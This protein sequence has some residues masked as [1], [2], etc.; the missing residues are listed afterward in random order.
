MSRPSRCWAVFVCL[1]AASAPAAAQNLQ[2]YAD[3]HTHPMSYLGFGEKAVHGA[4][5][6]GGLLPAGTRACNAT[7]LRATSIEQALGDCNS[8]HGGWG[9]D[10]TCGDYLRAL[11]INVAIDS[12][13]TYKL[14]PERNIHGDHEHAGAPAFPYWPHQTSI[15]HQQMWWQ[16]LKRAYDGGLRV[17]VALT[18][19][20]ELLAE[21]LNG[22]APYDDK[23]VADRQIDE[24]IRFINNPLNGGFMEIAYSS[25]DVRR[26]VGHDKLAIVLGMEVDQIGN[27][28]KPGVAINEQAVR[29]EIQRLYG[30]GIRYI[31][32]I[33][34]IDNSF[35]G[36]A[37]YSVLFNVANR[38]ANGYLYHIMTSPDPNVAYDA[39][40]L[41]ETGVENFA[42]VN[43]RPALQA[44][45]ETPAP[46]FNDISCFP[47]PGKVRCC[48]SYQSIVNQLSPS[49][50]WEVYRFIPTGH[51]N[52]LGLTPLGEVAIDEMMKLKIIIDVDHMSERSM[53][54]VIEIAERRPRRYPIVMGHNG[55]RLSPTK[56]SGD[57]ESERSAPPALVRRI[58]ALGG[59]FGVGTADTTPSAFIGSYRAVLAA[60]GRRAVAIGTDVDGFE[61]LPTHQMAVTQAASDAFYARFLAQ[62]GIAARQR[63]G[64]RTWDYVLDGGVSHYGLMPEFLF[65][66]RTSAGGAEV[67]DSLMTS[68]EQF[69]RMWE[70]AEGKRTIP[71][72]RAVEAIAAL[73]DDDPD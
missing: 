17:M 56:P 6:I 34:L 47:P 54:R 57:P 51:V 46:C 11:I 72:L 49:P 2:G 64:T 10:N 67:Y 48:G 25:A 50:D 24:A 41:A 58:S 4:P 36:S 14:P 35:G 21:I 44:V 9:L 31:F 59:M 8:T 33:H 16:W 60:M 40:L 20:N 23:R 26:I 71:G 70:R 68:A 27:F 29:S 5:D 66:V 39:R 18:V 15:L 69:A 65:D 43:L 22:N 53:T 73:D 19:N 42:I 28:G 37:V 45:G 52:T 62:S 30:K 63:T 7:E 32:P 3:L 38:R 61:R 12:N 55:L 13:F 1:A